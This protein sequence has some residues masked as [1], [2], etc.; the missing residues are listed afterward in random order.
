MLL[1]V[2][3]EM[4]HPHPRY[5]LGL[6]LEVLYCLYLVLMLYSATTPQRGSR[7][8][9]LCALRCELKSRNRSGQVGTCYQ[10]GGTTCGI[11]AC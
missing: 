3:Q 10:K 5:F 1:Y 11:L 8:G 6:I 7:V 4:G 2:V 9:A